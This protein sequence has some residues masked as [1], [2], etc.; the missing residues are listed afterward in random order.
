MVLETGTISTISK[1]LSQI[2]H[3]KAG[4]V[5]GVSPKDGGPRLRGAIESLSTISNDH[6]CFMFDKFQGGLL[7]RGP[8]VQCPGPSNDER[9]NTLGR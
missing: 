8:L 9:H 2:L 7:I 6:A 1:N 4:W 5:G 3:Q